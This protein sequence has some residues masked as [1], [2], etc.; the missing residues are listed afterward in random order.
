MLLVL[1]MHRYNASSMIMQRRRQKNSTTFSRQ[2]TVGGIALLLLL[3]VGLFLIWRARTAVPLGPQRTVQTV[4]PK[5]GVHTRLTDEVEPWKIKR[6]LQMVREMGA[7]WVVEYFPWAYH[8]PAPGR[9]DW[10]H[11]DLVVDH[12]VTQGLTVIARLGFV[13]TWARPL[14]TTFLYLDEVHYADFGRYVYEFVRHF[15]GRVH[16]LIIWNEPNLALEWGYRPVDAAAYTELLKVSYAQAKAADPDVQVLGG[17]LA[18]TLAPAGS[19]Y[20]LDDLVYLQQMYDAGAAPFFDILAAH[21]YG[22]VFDANDPPAS[23]VVNFRRVEL[24]R[25]VMVRNGDG[26]KK[27]IITEAGWN[28]HPRWTKAVRPAQRIQNTLEAFDLVG[29]WDWLQ[30]LCLWAFRYPAP[31][32]SYQDYFTFVASDFVPKPIYLELQAYAGE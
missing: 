21:A 10:A 2:W 26:A 18:P 5:M 27:I 19:A 24:L 12:A 14:D 25:A 20:G 29:Q 9:F 16:Y 7:P 28:D 11:A 32:R 17:A 31:T 6:T 8:E 3:A 30:A 4:N 22:W 23:D 15:K 1:P 13:P